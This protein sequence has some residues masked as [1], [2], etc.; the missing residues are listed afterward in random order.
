MANKPDCKTAILNIIALV[1][2]D[3]LFDDPNIKIWGYTCV[4]CPKK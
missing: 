2:D 4:I 1:K 3:S